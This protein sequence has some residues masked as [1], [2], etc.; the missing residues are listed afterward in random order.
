[1]PSLRHS[2]FVFYE[3]IDSKIQSQLLDYLPSIQYLALDGDLSYFSLDGLVNLKSLSLDGRIENDFNFDIFKNICNQLEQLS[4]N[5]KI[6]YK[7][8]LDRMLCGHVFSCL[9]TLSICNNF[10]TK[11]DKKLFEGFPMLQSLTISDNRL[12]Q[13]IENDAFSDLKQLISL[14]LSNNLIKTLSNQNFSGLEKLKY[15]NMNRNVLES[16]EENVFS[17]LKN[18]TVLNLTDNRLYKIKSKLTNLF[19]GLSNLKYLDLTFNSL[20]IFDLSIL[21]NLKRTLAHKA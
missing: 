12:L 3:K 17:G 7:S 9:I 2:K 16:V 4:I 1:M 11:L 14:D 5:L 15:L 20:K 8:A 18:L 13:K 21:K 10:I 19:D 6:N